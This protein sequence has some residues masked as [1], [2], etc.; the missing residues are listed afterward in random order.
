MTALAV[1]VL[2]NPVTQGSMRIR[3]GRITHDKNELRP[4]RE[5]IAWHVRQDMNTAGIIE[6]LQGPVVV[7][8][9]FTI[10]RPPSV[11]RSRWAPWKKPDIDKLARGLLD[12]LVLAGCLVDDGQVIDLRAAKVYPTD[13]NLPGVTFTVS[14]AERGEQVA[15]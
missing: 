12:A 5:L 6:P 8:A 14:P 7:R 13:G 2:G 9:T 15:A 1:T 3:R 10:R 4:W 11:P